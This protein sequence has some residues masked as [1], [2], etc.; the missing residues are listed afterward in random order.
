[1]GCLFNKCLSNACEALPMKL[2]R[3]KK[4]HGGQ[5]EM[6]PIRN[7]LQ[8]NKDIQLYSFFRKHFAHSWA[9]TSSI[10][11][12][13]LSCEVTHNVQTHGVAEV[14]HNREHCRSG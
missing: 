1:M 11:W 13:L 7:I 4:V 10:L 8:P 14:C 5:T 3:S 6:I 2:L 9:A 12:M